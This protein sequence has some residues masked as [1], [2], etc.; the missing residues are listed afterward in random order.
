[1]KILAR[2]CKNS[3]KYVLLSLRGEKAHKRAKKY[4]TAGKYAH[5]MSE[6]LS[7]GES[8]GEVTYYDG[9]TVNADLILTE[10]NV[11]WD[12]TA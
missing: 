2:K 11:H 1:M 4:L 5:A 12:L 8:L 6:I 10:K 7:K 3:G 9:R